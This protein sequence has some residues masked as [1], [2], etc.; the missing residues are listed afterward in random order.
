MV[1]PAVSPDRW[2]DTLRCAVEGER[3][4]A[5]GVH[6]HAYGSL[7]DG[8]II[9]ALDW[10]RQLVRDHPSRIVAV[11]EVGFD[12]QIDLHVSPLARQAQIVRWHAELALELDLPLV[13]HVLRAHAEAL[14]ALKTLKLRELAGVIHSYSG[15]PEL[16]DAYCRLGFMLSFAGSIVRQ[17]ARKPRAAVRLTPQDRLLVE[18]DAPDQLPFALASPVPGRCEPAHLTAIVAAAAQTRDTNVNEIERIT[19]QNAHRLFVI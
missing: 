3:W 4:V 7:T 5:L 18:T 6:P 16:V 17:D 1:I 14:A 12:Q 13:L 9:D 2:K 19:T 15:G 10:L 11:G 8:Q